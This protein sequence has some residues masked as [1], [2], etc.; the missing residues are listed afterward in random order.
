MSK[1]TLLIIKPDPKVKIQIMVNATTIYCCFSKIKC[2]IWEQLNFVY[3]FGWYLELIINVLFNYSNSIRNINYF[4]VFFLDS[5]FPKIKRDLYWLLQSFQL[6]QWRS[7]GY[8]T[9]AYSVIDDYSN[10]MLQDDWSLL[11]F[12]LSCDTKD[13]IFWSVGKVPDSSIS[14]LPKFSFNFS[15]TNIGLQV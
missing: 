14:S 1:L 11:C 6:T 15:S 12:F 13:L 4:I 7:S 2:R 9:S 10:I 3:L 8:F 5:I